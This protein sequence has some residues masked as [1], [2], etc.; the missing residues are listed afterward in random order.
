MNAVLYEVTATF[1]DP[2][3]VDAWVAWMLHEHLADV[4]A[5]GARR[6]ALIRLDSPADATP[7]PPPVFLA[8]Y[9]FPS[10]EAF[11]RYLRDHAPRLR[12]EGRRRFP[13]HAVTYTRRSGQVLTARAAT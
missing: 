4:L 10:R 13:P 1:H 12:E 8:S 9:E 5:A 11:D 7:E 6:A 2:T 3:V